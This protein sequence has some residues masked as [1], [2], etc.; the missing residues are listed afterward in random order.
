MHFLEKGKTGIS[1]HFDS[2]FVLFWTHC[3]EKGKNISGY[4]SR[5]VAYLSMA[6]LSL[7]LASNNIREMDIKAQCAKKKA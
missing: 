1:E 5:H 3:R 4:I 7:I 2:L 6:L